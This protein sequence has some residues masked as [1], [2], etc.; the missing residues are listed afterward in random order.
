MNDWGL[1]WAREP[2]LSRRP[3]WSAAPLSPGH[4]L[5]LEQARRQR[6]LA[7]A[8]DQHEDQ[9]AEGNDAA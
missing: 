3:K 6:L 9:R 2:R 1:V 7:A 5:L 8:A 4:M